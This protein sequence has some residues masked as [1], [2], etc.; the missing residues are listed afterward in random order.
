MTMFHVSPIMPPLSLQEHCCKSLADANENLRAVVAH[1]TH[2][3]LH[4]THIT[5]TDTHTHITHTYKQ[6]HAHYTHTH[7]Q[8]IT[9]LSQLQEHS[10]KTL[11][12][13]TDHL[14]AVVA[15]QAPAS[16]LPTELQGR[17]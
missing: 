7:T 2:Y 15:L 10:Y 12:D 14:R 5:S 13:A 8:E 3:T 6:T 9:P 17:V 1:I 4:I 11:A 16:T